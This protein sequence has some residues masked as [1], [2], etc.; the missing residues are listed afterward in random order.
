MTKIVTIIV[1]KRLSKKA[2]FMLKLSESYTTEALVFC[3]E[4]VNSYFHLYKCGYHH[5]R[6]DDAYLAAGTLDVD[7]DP[8]AH[9]SS[10]SGIRLG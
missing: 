2:D 5:N 4:V 8:V 9:C 1:N 7:D 3:T 10:R 6:I